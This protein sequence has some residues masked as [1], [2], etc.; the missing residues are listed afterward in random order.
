VRR[1]D[2]H[3][4]VVFT[5]GFLW[6]CQGYYRHEKG[7]TPSWPGMEDYQ[8]RIVHPQSW[9]D[10]LD[11]TSRRVIVIGSGATAATLIPNIAGQCASLTLLQRSPTYFAHADNVSELADRLRA[12]EIDES[13]VHEIVRRQNL[14]DEAHFTR[15]TFEEPETVRREL[16]E[17]IRQILGPETTEKH[18]TPRYRTWR[19]RLAFLPNADL[20]RTLQA[21]RASVVTDEIEC[22]TPDGVLLKSGQKLAADVIITATGFNLCVMGDIPFAVD[23]KP[24]DFARTV[25]YRGMM[26]TGVPNMAYVFGYLR[27]SWTLR[28]DLVAD[29]VCRLLNHMKRQGLRKVEV[30]LA[31]EAAALPRL[32][33]IDPE[34]FN[35]GYLM[36]ALHLMPKRLDRPEWQHSQDYGYDREAFPA[37]DLAG[38][39]F[40]YAKG[41]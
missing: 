2:T 18:F 40:V 21:G 6:M 20:L 30:V 4:L 19:Q 41:D 7:Y 26:F 15:R 34:N 37:I 11:L 27:S 38:P 28:A 36:R 23:A 39:E 16:L 35:P 22:F 24:V 12:L 33:W 29:F 3:E 32:P 1:A 31:E 10:D 9:P 13:W 5:A 17:G 25:T 14:S 8:G